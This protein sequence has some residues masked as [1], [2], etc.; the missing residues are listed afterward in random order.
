VF[1]AGCVVTVYQLTLR[2]LG[3]E[4]LDSFLT[5][6]QVAVS[7]TAALSGKL[8]PQLV[9][10]VGNNGLTMQHSPW[11]VVMPPAWFAALDDCLAGGMRSGSPMLAGM[12][13][14]GTAAIAWIAFGKLAK[15]F[16]AGMQRLNETV[17]A[18]PRSGGR[19][20][21]LNALVDH[22]PMRWWLADPT[23]RAAFLLSSAYLSRDRDTKL[24]IFPSIAPLMVLPAMFLFQQQEG[25]PDQT[26]FAVAMV[27]NWI[28]MLPFVGLNLLQYSQQ[29]QASDVFRAAPLAGPGALCQGAQR[30]MMFFVTVPMLVISVTL[31]WI[32]AH[33]AHRLLLLLPGIIA[34]P[35]F[36]MM[37]SFV[38][39]AI[40]LSR[41]TE[42]A[43]RANRGMF[44]VAF[45][46]IAT[47]LAGVVAVMWKM[48]RFR[49]M[50]IA[51]VILCSV[52][53][54][55]CRL[56][57]SRMRWRNEE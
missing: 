4:K 19:R 48:G 42:E 25:H 32:S 7:I 3:R 56:A 8:L 2:Y 50:I 53:F 39:G 30:A 44:M 34:L 33:D 23:A 18:T 43:S 31:V 40:P 35:V 17:G 36:S 49:Q 37:A 27:G 46:L 26:I 52:L 47:A 21:W 28:S 20:R 5:I 54:V 29:W 1:A 45:M 12:A 22:A 13:V 11:L 6:T 38:G 57:M 41:P 55:V 16:E 10:K 9:F 15:G 24:R 14:V 51:E